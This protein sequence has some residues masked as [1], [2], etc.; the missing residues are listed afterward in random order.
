[1]KKLNI[2]QGEVKISHEPFTKLIVAEQQGKVE[3]I[4]Q[5]S[6]R[7]KSQEEV[8]SNAQL[9]QDSFL[10]YN[11]TSIL[12]SELLKQRNELLKAL[13]KLYDA[14]DSCVELTP[15]VLHQSLTA[16]KNATNA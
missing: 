15:E 9:I 7:N 2:T 6:E 4:C 1:M 11:T 12:P 3:T 5:L 16:I 13:T 14:V 8:I 10:T